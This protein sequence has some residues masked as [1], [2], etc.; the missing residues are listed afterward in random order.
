MYREIK[1]IIN[2]KLV[3]NSVIQIFKNK[4]ISIRDIETLEVS[5]NGTIINYTLKQGKT[6]KTIY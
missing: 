4:V 2:I 1:Q 3:G 5:D 6:Y